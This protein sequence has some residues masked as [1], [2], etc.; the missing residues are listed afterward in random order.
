MVVFLVDCLSDQA[1]VVAT[2][3]WVVTTNQKKHMKNKKLIKSRAHDL[4]ELGQDDIKRFWIYVIKSNDPLACWQWTG[5]RLTRGYGAFSI[6]GSQ[7]KAHRISYLIANG[8]LTAGL[9]VMHSCDNPECTNPNHLSEGYSSD[10]IADM[11]AKG[12]RSELIKGDKHWTRTDPDKLWWKGDEHWTHTSPEKVKH[13]ETNPNCKIT[14]EI[15][16]DMRQRKINGE[17]L[18]SL[19]LHF[20]VHPETVGRICRRKLWKH[21]D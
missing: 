5:A 12:R 11:D 1:I 6:N 16:R 14:A 2:P 20:G 13:G 9:V 18:Q 21:I 4:S 10:N 3:Q 17:S 8:H 19:G 7:M 15:V